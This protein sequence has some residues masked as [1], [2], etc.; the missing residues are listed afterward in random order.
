[1]TAE[2]RS[3][4]G[5]PS[6]LTSFPPH[7]PIP[8]V[9]SACH[10]PTPMLAPFAPHRFPEPPPQPRASDVWVSANELADV[11]CASVGS[12]GTP[13]ESRGEYQKAPSASSVLR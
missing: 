2:P 8:P 7:S 5:G 4:R 3:G 10:I 1:M 13:F 12:G 9:A 6:W 11:Y